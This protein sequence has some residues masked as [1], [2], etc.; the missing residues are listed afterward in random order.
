VGHSTVFLFIKT[1]LLD[2]SDV[3]GTALA[4]NNVCLFQNIKNRTAP[5]P[6][7]A[8][9]FSL[10]KSFSFLSIIT[11]FKETT[12]RNNA[13]YYVGLLTFVISLLPTML[14]STKA[15]NF[16]ALVYKILTRPNLPFVS[17]LTMKGHRGGRDRHI[18][19]GGVCSNLRL[20]KLSSCL[21][22][23]NT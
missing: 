3:L 18:V 21:P 11:K 17:L 9:L 16:L 20:Y 7:F 15:L 22:H 10:L 19:R 13:L 4:A 8:P 6:Q 14:Y 5:L 12:N 23:F 2:R 1:Y